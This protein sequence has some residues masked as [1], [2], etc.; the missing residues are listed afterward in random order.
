MIWYTYSLRV[1]IILCDLSILRIINDEFIRIVI[2]PKKHV[3]IFFAHKLTVL[4]AAIVNYPSSSSPPPALNDVTWTTTLLFLQCVKREWYDRTHEGYFRKVYSVARTKSDSVDGGFRNYS[5]E[6]V[7]VCV[8]GVI[9]IHSILNLFLYNGE[10]L[11][12]H[13]WTFSFG[14]RSLFVQKF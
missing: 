5:R 10:R 9:K 12:T 4:V 7:Y 2:I 3:Q 1:N 14:P 6:G 11:F 8:W 13:K